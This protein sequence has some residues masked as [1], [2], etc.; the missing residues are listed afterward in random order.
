[1]FPFCTQLHVLKSPGT[2]RHLLEVPALQPDRGVPHPTLARA[3]LH[4]P[5]SPTPPCQE[6]DP[7]GP[8]CENPPFW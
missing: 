7:E 3:A 4:L 8:L 2:Q 1:M 6:K 5:L